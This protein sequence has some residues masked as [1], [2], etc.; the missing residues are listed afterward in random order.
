MNRDCPHCG[1]N[2]C[3]EI[4]SRP[5]ELRRQGEVVAAG[6]WRRMVCNFCGR[7]WTLADETE[8][9]TTAWRREQSRS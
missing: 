8:W 9:R 6:D 3:Q 7:R 5:Y 1:C 4:E 2:D